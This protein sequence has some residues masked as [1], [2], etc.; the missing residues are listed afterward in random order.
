VT[1]IEATVS[2]GGRLLRDSYYDVVIL[3]LPRTGIEY[4]AME[5]LVHT[6]PQ[7]IIYVSCDAATLARDGKRLGEAGYQLLVVQ[8]VD[9]FPQ[10]YHIECVAKF[11]KREAEGNVH[12][13]L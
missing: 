13:P 6:K 1:L 9:M 3:D 12:P 7:E 2:E 8:P 10:T 11:E 5:G 4:A